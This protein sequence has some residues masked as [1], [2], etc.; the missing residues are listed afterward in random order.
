MY[1]SNI[2]SS[3]I[4]KPCWGV[5]AACSSC[6]RAIC[7]VRA[8][9]ILVKLY[10]LSYHG[11]Y[12]HITNLSCQGKRGGEMEGKFELRKCSNIFT[13]KLHV[14][15]VKQIFS[16]GLCHD[17]N[18]DNDKHSDLTLMFLKTATMTQQ[19]RYLLMKMFTT[20]WLRRGSC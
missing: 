17:D 18:K 16:F 20:L 14:N 13:K 5:R 15:F 1:F 9:V 3:W 6:L 11:N 12:L 19:F 2:E 8:V 7:I 4:S 10:P